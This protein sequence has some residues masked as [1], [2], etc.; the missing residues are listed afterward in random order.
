M[1]VLALYNPGHADHACKQSEKIIHS[2]A[3]LIVNI[4]RHSGI[5]QWPGLP[6]VHLKA[7]SCTFVWA[8]FKA[9]LSP[10][11]RSYLIFCVLLSLLFKNRYTSDK[12]IVFAY[13]TGHGG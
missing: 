9:L 7:G 12:R 4:D 6:R 3:V 2:N 13:L 8:K 5:W 1:M 10:V 11:I